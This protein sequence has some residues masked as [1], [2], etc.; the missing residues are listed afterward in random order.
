[1]DLNHIELT[2]LLLTGLYKTHLMEAIGEAPVVTTNATPVT[3]TNTQ[4]KK[5]MPFLGKN[6][7]GICILVNYAKDV[8]LP[9]DQLNFITSILQACR[10][11][12]GDVAIVNQFREKASFE[13]IKNQLGC[14]HLLVFGEELSIPGLP[15]SPLFT[16]TET[17]GCNIVHSPAAGLLNNNDPG[18]KLLKSKLWVCLKEMFKV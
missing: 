9:D 11:N 13:D 14:Q 2:P 4:A 5:P 15:D 8:Y 18:N 12:L 17:G 6:Q 10:L 1:M 7:K 3:P 16:I